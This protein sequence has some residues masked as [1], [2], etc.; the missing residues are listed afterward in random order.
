MAGLGSLKSHGLADPSHPGR[1]W[2]L[3]MLSDMHVWTEDWN[4]DPAQ[5]S[6]QGLGHQHSAFTTL[7]VCDVEQVTSSLCGC[8]LIYKMG[9]R[10]EYLIVMLWRGKELVFVKHLEQCLAPCLLNKTSTD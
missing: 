9:I 3:K 6:Q 1:P 8:L 4:G 2:G 7:W 5:W 10:V